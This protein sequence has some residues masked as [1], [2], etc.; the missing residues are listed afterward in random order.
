MWFEGKGKDG[1]VFRVEEDLVGVC[2]GD[3][4]G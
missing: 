4:R 3:V 1:A 2:L